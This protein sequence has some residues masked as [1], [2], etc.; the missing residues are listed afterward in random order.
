MF[1]HLLRKLGYVPASSLGLVP[2]SAA[3]SMGPALHQLHSDG[4]RRADA[5]VDALCAWHG[6]GEGFHYAVGR[7]DWAPLAVAGFCLSDNDECRAWLDEALRARVWITHDML[8]AWHGA[9]RAVLYGCGARLD[10]SRPPLRPPAPGA[11]NEQ[12]IAPLVRA[13]E[14]AELFALTWKRHHLVSPFRKFGN[15]VAYNALSVHHTLRLAS[16]TNEHALERVVE[17]LALW[18]E[19]RGLKV[20]RK[21]KTVH[22]PGYQALFY[23][24]D[25]EM[26]P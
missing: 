7:D 11:G 14:M 17:W 18:F 21:E 12:E 8:A 19:A 5:D 9:N 3:C 25:A 10:Q 24:S 16:Q 23:R 13:T 15:S 4:F 22:L 20:D 26:W 2:N 6:D 1:D